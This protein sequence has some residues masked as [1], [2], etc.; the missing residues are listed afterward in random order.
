MFSLM[1]VN[2]L[3]HDLETKIALLEKNILGLREKTVPPAPFAK[4]V[5]AAVAQKRKVEMTYATMKGSRMFVEVVA[6]NK[7][8]EIVGVYIKHDACR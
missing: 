6:P 7:L 5:Y 2:E 3:P 4:E 8:R 1:Y